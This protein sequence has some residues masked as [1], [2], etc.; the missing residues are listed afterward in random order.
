MKILINEVRDSKMVTHD[1][2]VGGICQ[3][4]KLLFILDE[5][6]CPKVKPRPGFGAVV[7]SDRIKRPC[8]RCAKPVEITSVEI[9]FPTILTSG[10]F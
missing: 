8:P 6:D 3:K 4:C 7:P 2:G 1:C 9:N 5:K 10:D